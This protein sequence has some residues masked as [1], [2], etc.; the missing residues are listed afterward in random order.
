M[1]G[2][3]WRAGRSGKPRLRRSFAL[4]APG[5]PGE[6]V[7]GARDRSRK[8][9][10]R[11]RRARF[12]LGRVDA[13]RMRG[14]RWSAGRSGRPRLRR[15]FALPAPGLPA[16]PVHGARDHSRKKNG[17][18]GSQ[19]SCSA[20]STLA[21]MLGG[22]VGVQGEAGS[23]GSG[24]ASPYLSRGFRRSPYGVIP[25]DWFLAE[26]IASR[27]RFM[28]RAT[29]AEKRTAKRARTFSAAS[30]ARRMWGV[31]LE[32]RAKREAPAQAELRPTCAEASGGAGSW[33]AR[34]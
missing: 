1:G 31:A 23:P 19:G 10:R 4:P 27:S 28:A 17:E 33:R 22:D 24:G 8:K 11:H 2:W 21:E 25:Y 13:R 3:R 29:I 26:D 9:E 20:E 32:G 12:L 34:P 6:P 18:T 30:D 15:S 5:L 7:Y 16:E 14:W